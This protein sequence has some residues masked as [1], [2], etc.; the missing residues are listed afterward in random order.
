MVKE[1]AKAL[2]A[3]AIAGLT[4]LGAGLTDGDLTAAEW[5][6]AIIAALTA[7][8]VVYRVPNTARTPR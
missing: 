6:T 2:I 3:G 8:G 7:I 1:I 4:A 5:I